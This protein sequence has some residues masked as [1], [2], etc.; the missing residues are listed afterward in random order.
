M[1]SEDLNSF[2][3][4]SSM[5]NNNASSSLLPLVS[6]PSTLDSSLMNT[7]DVWNV[8]LVTLPEAKVFYCSHYNSVPLGS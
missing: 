4:A 5:I 2:N 7:S 6:T 8:P 3:Y 1:R